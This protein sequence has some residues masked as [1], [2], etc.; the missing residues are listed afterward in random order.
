M[1]KICVKCNREYEVPKGMPRTIRCDKC[2]LT[3]TYLKYK[4]WMANKIVGGSRCKWCNNSTELEYC[5]DGC[6]AMAEKAK[7]RLAV[8]MQRD[9]IVPTTNYCEHLMPVL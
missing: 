2:R 8:W 7:A 6:R 9:P 4:N 3:K 1:I 5:N